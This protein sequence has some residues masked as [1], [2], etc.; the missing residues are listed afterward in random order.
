MSVTLVPSNHRPMERALAA[1]LGALADADPASIEAMWNAW[2]CPAAF[3]PF[4]AWALSVDDWDDAWPE[5]TK[6]KVIAASPLYHRRKGTRLAV[7]QLLENTLRPFSLVEWFDQIPQGRR[8]TTRAFIE[9]PL[10]DV[11]SVLREVRPRVMAAKPKSRAV[12]L[13]VGEA[14]EATIHIGGAVSIETMTVI[15]PYAFAAE[16]PEG[17]YVV[18]FGLHIE[19]MTTIEAAP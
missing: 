7:E 3:L 14:A 17:P 6:R 8:G 2:R 10:P 5:V 18:A 9:A 4:L 11:A 1:A 15:D 12:F 13:G 19:T 16:D